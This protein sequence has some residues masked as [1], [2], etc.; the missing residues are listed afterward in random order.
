MTD[1]CPTCGAAVRVEASGVTHYMVPV[2]AERVRELEAKVKSL[3][4]G[5][6]AAKTFD[7]V[8]DDRI[9]KLEAGLRP[10]AQEG[11][12][13][14]LGGNVQGDDSPVYGREKSVLTLGDFR[15]AK[16]LLEHQ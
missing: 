2:D 15:R 9:R 5:L 1:H 11:F 6:E 3:T 8:V 12:Q 13:A 7:A 14:A 10:F 16:K 4:A